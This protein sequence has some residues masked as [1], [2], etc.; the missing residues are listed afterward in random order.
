[1]LLSVLLF[2]FTVE[3]SSSHVSFSFSKCSNLHSLFFQA[4]VHHF[5]IDAFDVSVHVEYDS[6]CSTKSNFSQIVTVP[7]ESSLLN[8]LEHSNQLYPVFNG[9]KVLYIANSSYFLTSLNNDSV[10][11]SCHW[12]VKTDPPTI[13]PPT[14]DKGVYIETID[15][16][17]NVSPVG[18]NN[19]YVTNIG[20]TVIFVCERVP[21]GSE[22]KTRKEEW[23][24]KFKGIN[25]T[26]IALNFIAS[27]LSFFDR[28]YSNQHKTL[29]S[30]TRSL[31]L[32]LHVPCLF[33]PVE[34]KYPQHR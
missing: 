15:G 34:E 24:S 21:D 10:T 29:V 4:F 12:T 7:R 5:G 13:N 22:K 23:L 31:V 9:F 8:V 6:A 16:I 2:L 19:A 3:I 11:P 32:Q 30:N 27:S 25:M 17:T 1:M 18:L 20:M 14:T 33:P 26:V 28:I